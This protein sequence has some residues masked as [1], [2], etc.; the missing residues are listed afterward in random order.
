MKRWFVL[1]RG[2]PYDGD[3]LVR[4]LK[5]RYKARGGCRTLEKHDRAANKNQRF[6]D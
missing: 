5:S 6:A 3:I 1:E 4:F 2:H